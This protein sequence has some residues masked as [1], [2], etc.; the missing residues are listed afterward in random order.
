[1]CSFCCTEE[2]IEDNPY[3]GYFNNKQLERL[4]DFIKMGQTWDAEI[5]GLASKF[6]LEALT[7]YLLTSWGHVMLQVHRNDSVQLHC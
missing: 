3:P 2:V 4:V 1:M 5:L 7:E 6:E